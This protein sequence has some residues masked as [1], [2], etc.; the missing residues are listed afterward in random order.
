MKSFHLNSNILKNI[1]TKHIRQINSFPVATYSTNVETKFK[2]P[3][4]TFTN[5]KTS[6]AS[7][8]SEIPLISKT[9]PEIIKENASTD[10]TIYNF[11]HQG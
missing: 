4:K 5:L 7:S 8:I 10:L 3:Y 6:Y 1:L 9:I 11:P 2:D